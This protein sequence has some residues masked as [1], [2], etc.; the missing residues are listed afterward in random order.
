MGVRRQTKGR[1]MRSRSRLLGVLL[2]GLLA[3]ASLS[4]AAC[5]S[6]SKSSSSGGSGGGSSGSSSAVSAEVAKFAPLTKAPAGAKKGGTLTL[7]AKGDV[8]YIDPGA[9]YTQWGLVVH[10]SADSPLMGWPPSD[11]AAP[12]PLLAASQPTVTDGGKT[13]TFK[14]KPNI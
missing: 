14:I 7:I 6:S 11:N 12:V 3:L 5:G 4:V 8:D 2:P 1:N 10:L 9:S 13:I